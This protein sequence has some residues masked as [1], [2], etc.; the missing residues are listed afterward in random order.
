VTAG[1]GDAVTRPAGR[2]AHKN[3]FIVGGSSGIGLASARAFAEEGGRVFLS[4]RDPAKLREAAA[5]IG[6]PPANAIVADIARTDEVRAMADAV[7]R[8]AGRLDVLFVNAGGGGF[9]PIEAVTE[10]EWD[11]LFATNL[12]G[13]FFS[14]QACLPLLGQ[15]SAI[16]LTSSV[17]WKKALPG[18][19]AYAASKAG[20]HALGRALAADLAPRAI[21]VNV[22]TPGPIETPIFRRDP[23]VSDTDI[24]EIKRQ[25]AENTLMKRIGQAEEV[26]RAALFL[27]SGEASFITAAD[28]FVDGGAAGS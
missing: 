18:S 25:M 11:A 4:G 15:G 28:L 5:S 16:L 21:R 17:A 8:Q 14:I 9:A 3:I 2:F 13:M 22:V 24:A 12:K 6:M 7:A 1:Q 26:A 23:K 27:A 19:A 20:V 10:A